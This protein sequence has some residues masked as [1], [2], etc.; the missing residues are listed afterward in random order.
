MSG[1]PAKA[2]RT[3]SIT[4]DL[5]ALPAHACNNCANPT[6]LQCTATHPSSSTSG[7]CP[8]FAFYCCGTC[9]RHDSKDHQEKCEQ[10]EARNKLFKIART[11]R[12]VWLTIRKNTW[13]RDVTKV[14]IDEMET[15]GRVFC[16]MGSGEKF[17]EGTVF[18][19]FDESVMEG[20]KTK[21]GVV[22]DAVLT[23]STS[24]HA[25]ACLFKLVEYLLQGM[26]IS[27]VSI[28]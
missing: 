26:V 18:H 12:E 13:D 17:A 28:V 8:V 19:E 10:L 7:K 21:Y 15:S 1:S 25:I 16:N 4:R 3:P 20:L 9:Q 6:T 14:S 5:E 24:E 23:V 11:V 22:R 27:I 2:L